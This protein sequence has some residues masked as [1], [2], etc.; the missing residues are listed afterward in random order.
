MKGD[1]MDIKGD[2]LGLKMESNG[3][4][5]LEPFDASLKYSSA[6][7]KTNINLG[8]SEI[9]M[10]FSFSI[11]RLFLAVQDDILSFMQTSSKRA[12]ELCSQFDNVATI[13]GITS[14]LCYEL[15]FS[16]LPMTQQIGVHKKYEVD[17]RM[18]WIQ[19]YCTS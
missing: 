16:V 10:N 2:I 14:I 18:M 15:F 7:G 12:T 6:S 1:S 8:F 5:V 17:I 3:I 13:H 4:R 9:D 11:L 19:T